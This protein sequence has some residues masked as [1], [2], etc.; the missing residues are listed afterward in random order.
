M[1]K[2]KI[3]GELSPEVST[4]SSYSAVRRACSVHMQI[5]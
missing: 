3:T 5:K 4:L 2:M 1:K